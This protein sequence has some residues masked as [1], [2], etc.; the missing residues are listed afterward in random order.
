MLPK[1]L[2]RV[3]FAAAG[4]IVAMSAS[5][6]FADPLPGETPKFYQAP[7]YNSNVFGG[8]RRP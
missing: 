2:S 6:A 8:L 3:S 1:Y 5:I 4:A 7:L